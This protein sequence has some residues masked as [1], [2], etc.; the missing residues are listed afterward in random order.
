MNIIG[1]Y[2]IPVII[3]LA[4][5]FI[6]FSK[7]NLFDE[8]LAGGKE[9][10]QTCAKLLPSLVMLICATRM[11]S[12]SG[13][14]DAICDGI[15]I[16]T[17]RLGI[18]DSVIPVILMRPISG[19][20]ATAMINNLF[21]IDGPDSFAGRCASILMG[22]SD[23]IIYTLAMYFGAAG[24]KKTRYAL[25]ASFILLGFCTV[26]SVIITGVFFLKNIM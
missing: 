1:I 8:F 5:V 25:P 4:G 15:G 11:F 2:A 12:A 20:A 9:G 17:R 22:S 26:L 3:A 24:I 16:F 10:A 23:T 19:S 14:L 6:L 13:A 7:N 18:P 21:S